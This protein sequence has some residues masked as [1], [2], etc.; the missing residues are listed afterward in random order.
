MSEIES[1][2]MLDPDLD[3]I[4]K[5]F[6]SISDLELYGEENRPEI[7]ILVEQFM[8]YISY[9]LSFE[10]VCP[11]AIMDFLSSNLKLNSFR[12]LLKKY[13]DV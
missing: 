5:S 7:K 13:E 4:F 10:E 6:I 11:E 9:Y 1:K 8:D 2:L 3:N 12:K